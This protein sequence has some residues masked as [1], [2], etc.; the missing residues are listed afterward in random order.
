V[1]IVSPRH[2]DAISGVVPVLVRVSHLQALP[3]TAV[4]LIQVKSREGNWVNKGWAI[5]SESDQHDFVFAPG[6]DTS[7]TPVGPN[8]IRAVLYDQRGGEALAEAAIA[9]TVEKPGIG[10]ADVARG[11]QRKRFMTNSYSWK[12]GVGKRYLH[13][14]TG[15][16]RAYAAECL[17]EFYLAT[18]RPNKRHSQKVFQYANTSIVGDDAHEWAAALRRGVDSHL[19]RWYPRGQVYA[20]GLEPGDMVFWMRGVNGY[21]YAHGHVAIVTDIKDGKVIVSE[22]SSSRG[23]GTHEISSSALRRMAGVMRWHR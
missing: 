7:G 4:V 13:K 17:A 12:E 10:L 11:A 22:N 6:W 8:G 9:V 3:E 15:L 21:T 23:I 18:G 2:G 14:V 20:D 19:G 16:C 1:R 5:W